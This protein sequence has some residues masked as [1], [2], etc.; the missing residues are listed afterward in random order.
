MVVSSLIKND[1]IPFP[2]MHSGRNFK[3][4]IANTWSNKNGGFFRPSRFALV[5]RHRN[6]A[7]ATRE[8]GVTPPAISKRLAELE[9]RRVVRLMNRTTRRLGL[10]LEGDLYLSNRSRILDERSEL[11]HLARK[12]AASG[13]ESCAWMR[14]LNWVE[15]ALHR[16]CRNSS[17]A[18]RQ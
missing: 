2:Q 8:L 17:R 18:I 6:L 4:R 7:R 10:T 1:K 5:A 13:R 11:E 12:A 9:R 15:R 16:P 14:R 3:E